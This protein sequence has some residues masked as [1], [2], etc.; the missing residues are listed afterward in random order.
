[1]RSIFSKTKHQ[2]KQLD[3][4]NVSEIHEIEEKLLLDGISRKSS[5]VEMIVHA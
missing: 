3:I 5:K 2:K 1:M 4:T